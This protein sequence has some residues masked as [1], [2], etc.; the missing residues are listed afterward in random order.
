MQMHGK[1]WMPVDYS[2]NTFVS[3]HMTNPPAAVQCFVKLLIATIRSTSPLCP[4]EGQVLI[5]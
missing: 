1:L 2:V 4:Q 5:C 3:V